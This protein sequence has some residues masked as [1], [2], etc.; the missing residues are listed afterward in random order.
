MATAHC[1]NRRCRAL[2]VLGAFLWSVTATAEQHT[3]AEPADVGM[4]AERLARIDRSIDEAIA[5]GEL[6]GATAVIARRGEI[7]YSRA[8]GY[9]DV[10]AERP[11]R[12]DSM[13][14]LYSMTKPVVS[15]ALLV[16]YEEGLF[17]LTD[18][19]EQYIPGFR[20]VQVLAGTD[21]DGEMIL[22]PARRPPTVQDAMRHTVGLASGLGP[23][24]VNARYRELG[25]LME[26]VTS[27]SGLAESIA[28]APLEHH[29]GE[30]WLYGLEHD[31]QAYLVEHFSGMALDRFLEERLFGPLGM[32]ETVFGIPAALAPRFAHSYEP[33]P[34]EGLTLHE[35]DTTGLYTRF[36]SLALGTIGLSSTPSDFLRFAS[37]LLNGGELDGT[38]ILA[39]KT[40]ELLRQNHLP[41][42]VLA[43]QSGYGLGFS[44][45][46][47]AAAEGNLVSPGTF[48]WSGAATTRFY[49]DPEEELVAVF[50]AQRWPYDDR[51]L[52]LFQ[53]LMYQAIID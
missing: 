30:R 36:E 47:S 26:D 41:E 31:I 13:F 38:R 16:L 53:T 5:R 1:L 23:G 37:M 49:I 32:S 20:D 52:N 28:T 8:F 33:V 46:L 11:M 9:A 22:E 40:V 34:G 39:P 12:T 51:T 14:R 18:P 21:A 2:V 35:T 15:V 27:L 24:P 17:Q 44:V 4:S 19:L 7:V 50:M 10:E 42:G 25:L 45:A 48:G 6:A 29:P 43:A 3:T